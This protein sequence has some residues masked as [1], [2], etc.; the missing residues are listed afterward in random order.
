M[1]THLSMYIK[2]Y[3]SLYTHG[4]THTHICISSEPALV[5]SRVIMNFTLKYF[6]CIS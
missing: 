2:I 5:E 6:K 3:T 1:H 4:H